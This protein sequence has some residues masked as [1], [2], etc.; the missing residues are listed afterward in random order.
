MSFRRKNPEIFPLSLGFHILTK[1]YF[2][3][4]CCKT[5]NFFIF[6]PKSLSVQLL[7]LSQLL[8]CLFTLMTFLISNNSLWWILNLEMPYYPYFFTPIIPTFL[9]F[10]PN[11]YAPAITMSVALSVTRVRT[12]VLYIRTYVC[13]SVQ[14]RTLSK[15]NTFDQNFMKLGH[16]V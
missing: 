5:S 9:L 13:T 14:R 6:I 1:V 8:S 12:Y 15:S 4:A 10:F 3:G 16:I 11:F 7:P 2:K